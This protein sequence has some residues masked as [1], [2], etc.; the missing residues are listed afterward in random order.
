MPTFQ[1]PVQHVGPPSVTTA[2]QPVSIRS[3]FGLTGAQVILGKPTHV[4]VDF[5]VTITGK[6]T[7]GEVY[8]AIATMNEELTETGSE[9]LYA[10]G[11]LLYRKAKFLGFQQ[12]GPLFLDA[13]GVN[14]W[15]VQ[16]V[17]RY[18]AIA[19]EEGKP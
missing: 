19:E 10:H 2:E 11:D 1:V 14:G 9:E 15:T 17:V 18:V 3:F 6:D 13:T 8:E 12:R 7:R 5:D 16:G 4:F